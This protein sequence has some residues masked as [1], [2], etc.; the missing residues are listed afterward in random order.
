[1]LI[2]WNYSQ[3]FQDISHRRVSLNKNSCAEQLALH[4]NSWPQHHP[5]LSWRIMSRPRL[6]DEPTK[7][8][9]LLIAT[10]GRGPPGPVAKQSYFDKEE[11]FT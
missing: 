8:P 7:G 4:L 10:K 1:M 5:L 6:P 11:S 9:A 3:V 2:G